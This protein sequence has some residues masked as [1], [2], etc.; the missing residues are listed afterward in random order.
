MSNGSTARTLLLDPCQALAQAGTKAQVGPP[1]IVTGQDRID[2]SA[3]APELQQLVDYLATASG[4]EE[5]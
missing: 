2:V 4:G 5:K 3:Y 1:D